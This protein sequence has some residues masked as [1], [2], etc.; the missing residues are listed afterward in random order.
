M[1]SGD[2]TTKRLAGRALVWILA[3]ASAGAIG[4]VI[5]DYWEAANPV[6]AVQSVSIA[7]PSVQS[8]FAFDH[9]LT[10]AID[11]HP[12]YFVDY[13]QDLTVPGLVAAIDRNK[14]LDIRHQVARDTLERLLGL[15]KSTSPALPLEMRR[16]KFMGVWVDGDVGNLLENWAKALLV[17][18]EERLPLEYN[19]HPEGSERLYVPLGS[20]PRIHPPFILSFDPC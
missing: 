7:A 11:Q 4:A 20:C 17:T 14:D 12:Y 16:E 1:G 6:I 10:I 13:D 2:W 19:D 3:T 18:Y 8:S 15:V 5:K 9:D